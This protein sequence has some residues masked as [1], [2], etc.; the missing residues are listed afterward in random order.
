MQAIIVLFSVPS[1]A[2]GKNLLRNSQEFRY[3][4]ADVNA[5][6]ESPLICAT[7]DVADRGH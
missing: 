4:A 5:P 2:Y 3:E 6:S 7:D 1:R